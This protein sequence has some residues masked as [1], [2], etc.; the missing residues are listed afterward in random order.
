MLD[1]LVN[2]KREPW[3]VKNKF[4]EYEL[5]IT[6]DNGSAFY[7]YVV[8]NSLSTWHRIVDIVKNGK[9]NISF[10]IFNENKKTSESE[11]VPQ[12][13]NFNCGK[14]HID[15]SLKKDRCYLWLTKRII[16]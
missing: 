15:S 11:Y 8:L 16:K 13:I 6:V 2:L 4:V 1:W 3:K 10:K 9:D 7:T 12:Y 5:Q 14:A